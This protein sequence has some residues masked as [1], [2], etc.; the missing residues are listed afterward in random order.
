MA[1]PIDELR[2]RQRQE[3][4]TLGVLLVGIALFVAWLLWDGMLRLERAERDRLQ[5]QS[6]AVQQIL[7]QQL[8]STY[9]AMTGVR[10]NLSLWSSQSDATIGSR[11]LKSLASAVPGVSD[12]ALLDR[13]GR[14]L[15]SSRAALVGTAPGP[16]PSPAD[17]GRLL[18]WPPIRGPGGTSLILLVLPVDEAGGGGAVVAAL[19]V[20]YYRVVLRSALYASDMRAVIAHGG[21]MVTV[22]EPDDPALPG[23]S[24]V[25][26]GS[27]FQRHR[28][29]GRD[30]SLFEGQLPWADA[31]K[32]VALHNLQPAG[33]P[34][35][36]PLVLSISRDLV[37]VQAPW[38]L[39]AEIDLALFALLAV[40][41]ASSLALLQRRQSL[42]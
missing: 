42:G 12:L 4:W 25:R 23:T 19:D 41:L 34:M 36:V 35:N 33:V 11:R 14:V 28:D 5:V 30:D 10:D 20:D 40:G 29:S 13:Q 31:P 24:L 21:G 6:R 16:H 32:L 3:W 18:V 26:A 7:A 15:S 17:A 22:V 38:R 9:D 1:R 8:H 27:F 37:A 39:Q 2:R